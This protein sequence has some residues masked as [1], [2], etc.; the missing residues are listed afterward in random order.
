M[1][2]TENRCYFKHSNQRNCHLGGAN[3]GI[4][5]LYFLCWCGV[6]QYKIKRAY[7]RRNL[8]TQRGC[9]YKNNRVGNYFL[10]CTKQGATG[11]YLISRHAQRKQIGSCLQRLQSLPKQLSRRAKAT[12]LRSTINNY[13]YGY[14]TGFCG[15]NNGERTRTFLGQLTKKSSPTNHQSHRKKK[16]SGLYYPTMAANWLAVA[17]AS[18]KP[19]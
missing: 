6:S 14:P 10:R 16:S 12:G 7:R 17:S 9:F 15:H 5:L 11:Q 8:I 19:L 1:F 4:G 3:G 2:S 13:I 18:K